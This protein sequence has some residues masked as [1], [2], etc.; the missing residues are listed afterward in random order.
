MDVESGKT[1]EKVKTAQFTLFNSSSCDTGLLS[2]TL[3]TTRLHRISRMP[4]AVSDSEILIRR[5]TIGD[6]NGINTLLEDAVA[7]SSPFLD[8]LLPKGESNRRLV[9]EY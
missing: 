3:N 9:L 1:N 7:R 5:A 8:Y 2:S 6:A 4:T